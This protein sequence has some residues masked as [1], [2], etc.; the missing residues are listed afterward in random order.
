MQK[1]LDSPTFQTDVGPLNKFTDAEKTFHVEFQAQQL[2]GSANFRILKK[3]IS[4]SIKKGR[5]IEVLRNS[6]TEMVIP[7]KGIY[8]VD[9]Q[10]QSSVSDFRGIDIKIHLKQK[11]SIFLTSK[12]QH[13]FA[14]TNTVVV[15]E[16][17]EIW[18]VSTSCEKTYDYSYRPNCPN[19]HY[20]FTK[21]SFTLIKLL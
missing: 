5:T 11:G 14:L 6:G 8:F 10:G 18:S 2:A 17:N 3:I 4:P 1:E 15:N 19:V 13:Q 12:D 7:F 9:W 16:N 21:V 20:S